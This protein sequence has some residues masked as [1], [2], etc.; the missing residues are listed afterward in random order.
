MSPELCPLVVWY[1]I[2]HERPPSALMA[3]QG[4]IT[5]MMEISEAITKMQQRA[6]CRQP[7]GLIC[8]W[9]REM[10]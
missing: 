10:T 7:N 5:I 4:A 9:E 6:Y 1:L 3:A 2:T 8:N